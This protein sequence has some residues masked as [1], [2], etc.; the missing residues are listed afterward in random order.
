LLLRCCERLF[1][2]IFDNAG[3][4]IFTDIKVLSALRG[5]FCFRPVLHL[6]LNVQ[7]G[8]GRET[9]QR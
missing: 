5:L 1:V 9:Q 8:V 4:K 7:F 2:M 3:Y 6:I